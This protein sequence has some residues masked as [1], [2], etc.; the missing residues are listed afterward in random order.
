MVIHDVMCVCVCVCMCVCVCVCV[1]TLPCGGSVCHDVTPNG[2]LWV[3]CKHGRA[4]HLRH[5]LVCN[6]NGNAKLH[7]VEQTWIKKQPQES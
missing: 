6:H 3:G 4:I 7:L 2:F 5:N 1:S